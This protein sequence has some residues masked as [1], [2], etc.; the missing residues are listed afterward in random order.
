MTITHLQVKQLYKELL[1]Y[2]SNLKLTDKNY[3]KIRIKQEFLDN[4]QLVK[5]EE[6]K[7]FYDKGRELLKRKSIV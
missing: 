4:K 6:I 5:P 1:K 7:F 2:G 3:Y